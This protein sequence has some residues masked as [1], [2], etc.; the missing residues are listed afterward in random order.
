MTML[1]SPFAVRG[2]R[3][4]WRL[5]STPA[6]LLPMAFERDPHL[7]A[8]LLAHPEALGPDWLWIGQ[9]VPTPWGRRIDLLAIDS[10]W[11]LHA[12]FA[13]K[14]ARCEAHLVEALEVRSFLSGMS[15]SEL[16]PFYQ[17]GMGLSLSEAFFARFGT[18]PRPPEK[19]TC[20][21]V[22]VLPETH[23]IRRAAAAASHEHC[24]IRL[25]DF[26]QHC[27]GQVPILYLAEAS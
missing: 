17:D 11:E 22:L 15:F 5:G 26:A 12:V 4:L 25:F 7:H 14:S 3:Q 1:A 18:S 27:D 2:E 16:G 6:K 9:Q 20:H 21:A 10:R 19:L 8:F 23:R 13:R 24:Q